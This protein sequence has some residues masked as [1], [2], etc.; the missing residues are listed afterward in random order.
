MRL[1]YTVSEL[2]EDSLMTRLQHSGYPLFV[3][4]LSA[5]AAHAQVSIAPTAPKAQETV[6]LVVPQYVI[7][8]TPS[9][10]GSYDT[11]LGS[12]TT[13]TMEANRIS[14]SVQLQESGFGIAPPSPMDFVLGQF[15]PGTYD[16]ELSRRTPTGVAAG[17]VGTARFTIPPRAQAEPLRNNTD[18]W[19]NAAESGWG[20]NIIQHGAGPI[21]ATW[22]VYGNDGKPDWYVVPGGQWTSEGFSGKIYRTTG[23]AFAL[24][25]PRTP[26]NP[27]FNPAAVGVTEVGT[28]VFGFN[29]QDST[30]GSLNFTI[31][32]LVFQKEIVRQPF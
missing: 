5:L 2:P 31:D 29:N 21:F 28:A 24:C 17:V 9:I 10:V 22:F 6:R 3:L 23:P 1:K 19:W 26:C 11:Y 4:L 7:D 18:L 8:R 25:P 14:V 12:A 13:V 20:I 27:V 32:G 30:K 15:P 16:V